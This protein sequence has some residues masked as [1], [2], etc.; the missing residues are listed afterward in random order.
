[1]THRGEGKISV[2]RLLRP[3]SQGSAVRV[4]VLSRCGRCA[5][6]SAILS[7]AGRCPSS[8]CLAC[9]EHGLSS[10]LQRER[11]RE[12]TDRSGICLIT[13]LSFQLSANEDGLLGSGWPVRMRVSR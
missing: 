7:D 9:S 5:L 8:G 6:S 11:E 1:M 4:I 3:Y 2:V 12:L 13:E 10:S